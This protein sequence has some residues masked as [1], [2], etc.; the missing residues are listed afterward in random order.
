M[1][2]PTSSWMIEKKIIYLPLVQQY[3]WS[4]YWATTI[5]FTVGFGDIV[6][7]TANEALVMIFI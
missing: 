3:I 7:T 4:Y 6:P 1:A 5:M 2:S